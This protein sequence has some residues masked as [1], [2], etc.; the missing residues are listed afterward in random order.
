[1][2]LIIGFYTYTVQT[3]WLFPILPLIFYYSII[4]YNYLSSKAVNKL[5]K[6]V[7]SLIPLVSKVFIVIYLGYS[8]LLMIWSIYDEH[9]SPYGNY[10]IKYSGIYDVQEL[11]MWLSDNSDKYYSYA[12]QHTE[13]LDI[14]IGT[15]GVTIPFEQDPL[16]LLNRLERRNVK[17]IL[18]D[19]SK[20][21]LENLVEPM[22]NKYP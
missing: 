9:R 12:D 20:A 1:M 7:T 17:Y 14:I 11:A 19:K 4:S 13:I 5:S 10:P 8:T 15:K 2:I 22:I 18:I 16:S 3:R 21:G 6:E